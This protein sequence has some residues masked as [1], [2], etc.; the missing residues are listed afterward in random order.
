MA[1]MLPNLLLVRRWQRL[2]RL[3]T[4]VVLAAYPGPS[5]PSPLARDKSANTLVRGGRAAGT[6]WSLNLTYVQTLH[7][8]SP[9]NREATQLKLRCLMMIT[10]TAVSKIT[11]SSLSC[12]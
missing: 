9:S 3:V 1:N 11:K 12:Y 5:P 6:E 7:V 4:A 2:E 10:N 8:T